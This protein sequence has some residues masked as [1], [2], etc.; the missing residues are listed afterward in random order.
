[1]QNSTLG[2]EDALVII[3]QIAV[4]VNVAIESYGS[5][6]YSCAQCAAPEKLPELKD[7]TNDR[8]KLNRD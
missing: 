1:M 2:T 8:R 4:R 5:H 7:D 6:S 3:S